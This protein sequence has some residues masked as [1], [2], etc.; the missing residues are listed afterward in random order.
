MTFQRECEKQERAKSV[1]KPAKAKS[2]QSTTTQKQPDNPPPVQTKS[3]AK[4][5]QQPEEND[6]I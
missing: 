1:L 6:D 4:A 5:N 2:M 3:P